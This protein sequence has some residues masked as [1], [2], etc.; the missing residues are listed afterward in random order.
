MF[1]V[2]PVTFTLSQGH[3][4]LHTLKTNYRAKFHDSNVSSLRDMWKCSI[5]KSDPDL[6]PG[7]GETSDFVLTI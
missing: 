4:Q 6:G 5:F 2:D 7:Q 3:G 1:Y